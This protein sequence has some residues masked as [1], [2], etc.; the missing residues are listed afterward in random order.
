MIYNPTTTKRNLY[1]LQ[2]V[3]LTKQ[4]IDDYNDLMET[5]DSVS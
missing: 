4:Y 3:D 2:P 1:I 5:K